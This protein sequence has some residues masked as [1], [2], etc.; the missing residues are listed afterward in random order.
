MWLLGA[1]HS[2]HEVLALQGAPIFDFTKFYEKLQNNFGL[3]RGTGT[4]LGL[5]LA[6]N[7]NNNEIKIKRKSIYL[8]TR[9]NLF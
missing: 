5:P 1:T 9:L 2:I 8:K 6:S 4:H 3:G 7:G